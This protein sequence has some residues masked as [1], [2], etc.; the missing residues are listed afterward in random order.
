MACP[1]ANMQEE[2]SI[3]LNNDVR[4]IDVLVSIEYWEKSNQFILLIFANDN[5][6]KYNM[7]IHP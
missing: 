3:C 2:S 5:V 1:I 6:L 7:C 4:T